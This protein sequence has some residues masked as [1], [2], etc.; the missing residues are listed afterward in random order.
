MTTETAQTKPP[1]LDGVL[2]VG[3]ARDVVTAIERFSLDGS[4]SPA[5]AETDDMSTRTRE[6]GD[7]EGAGEAHTAAIA[8]AASFLE[9]T[10]AA[11]EDFVA[12]A[13]LAGHDGELVLYSQWKR[14]GDVP[15]DLPAAWS[16]APALADATRVDAR[17]YEVDFTEPGTVSEVSRAATPHAH[18][19]V[20]T[21]T[22]DTQRELLD[23]AGRHG[24]TSMGTPGL[25][26]INFHRSLD[27]R[28]VINLGL[29][30]GFA[31]FKALISRPGFTGGEEYWTGVAGFRPHY[32]DVV[33]VVGNEKGTSA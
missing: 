16:L 13:L 9:E 8:N 5:T 27:G 2:R 10:L 18:F 33:A 12:A 31:D 21:V 22:P 32:F 28:R 14:G 20:F 29:W 25:T 26:A 24:P 11:R 17:T 4:Q 19:G 15:A 6:P 1:D 3:A 7:L 30:T 23:L